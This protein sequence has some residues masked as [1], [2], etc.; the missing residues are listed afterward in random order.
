MEG[1]ITEGVVSKNGRSTFD[2]NAES[3]FLKNFSLSE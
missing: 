2:L 3:S 1:E